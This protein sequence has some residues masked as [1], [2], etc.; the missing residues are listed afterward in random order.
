MLGPGGWPVIKNPDEKILQ[1][2]GEPS[3]QRITWGASKIM[4]ENG[5]IP[6]DGVILT[7]IQVSAEL[8][9]LQ[10]SRVIVGIAIR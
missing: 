4:E 5:Y 3:P 10:V 8:W 9:N 2:D 6:S 1:S 7:W